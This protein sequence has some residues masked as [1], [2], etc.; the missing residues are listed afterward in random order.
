MTRAT[1]GL[2]LRRLGEI[3]DLPWL[4]PLPPWSDRRDRQVR[5]VRHTARRLLRRR[6]VARHGWPRVLATAALWPALA[7]GKSLAATRTGPRIHRSFLHSVLDLWW[8]QLAHNFRIDDLYGFGVV[9][10]A[11]R[12]AIRRWIS[13]PENTAL[14][15]ALGHRAPSRAIRDKRTFAAFCARHGLPSVPVLA[16]GAGDTTEHLSRDWPAADLFLKPADQWGGHGA[17][18]LRHD[19]P[20]ALWRD[21]TGRPLGPETLAAYTRERF[22]HGPWILQPRLVNGP[23]LGDLASPESALST[24]RVVTLRHTPGAP[25]RIVFGFMRFALGKSPVDNLSSGGIGADYDP[26]T[27]RMRCA[28]ASA[29][30]CGFLTHH[31]DTGARIEG[32]VVPCWPEIAALALRAHQAVPDIDSFGWDIA[33]PPSGPVLIEANLHWCIP[34]DVPLGETDYIDYIL[35][36]GRAGRFRS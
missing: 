35:A 33:I 3:E 32:R 29:H 5:T 23:A 12:R 10:P 30:D 4:A 1:I 28:R 16:A 27:G 26:D 13:D 7:L 11:N 36:Q 22:G 6:V 31:P 19:S 21:D 18:I 15:F 2:V 9:A 20:A 17:C 8:L 14:L 24:V 34:T 25:P